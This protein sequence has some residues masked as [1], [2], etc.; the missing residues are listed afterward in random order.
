MADRA[1]RPGQSHCET[2]QDSELG[3]KCLGRGD[4]N[5]GA[6]QCRQYDVGLAG[7]RAFRLVHDRDDF[8]ALRLCITQRRQGVGGLARLRDEYRRTTA[9][10]CRGAIAELRGD[11][12]LDRNAGDP[13]EP[14]LG[15]DAGMIGGAACD[16]RHPVERAQ[17]KR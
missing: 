3:G 15:N 13:L 5:F 17:R 10:H 4:A 1:A 7:D 11:V 8:L 14:V 12:D 6:G 16:H 2:G 9:R